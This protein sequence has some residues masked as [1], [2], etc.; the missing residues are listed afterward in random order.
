MKINLSKDEIEKRTKL[1]IQKVNELHTRVIKQFFISNKIQKNKGP[2]LLEKVLSKEVEFQKE[3]KIP[4]I[5][6]LF[7]TKITNS[8][9]VKS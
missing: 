5:E 1:N 4:Q 9:E 6:G 8:I 2:T 3:G 7:H